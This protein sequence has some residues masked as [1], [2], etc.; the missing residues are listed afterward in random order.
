MLSGI[1]LMPLGKTFRMGLFFLV[2]GSLAAGYI[3]HDALFYPGGVFG[4]ELSNYLNG[5]VGAI[6]TGLLLAFSLLAFLIV[7][8]NFSFRLAP[9]PAL[10]ETETG[11]EEAE[12]EI[13]PRNVLLKTEE[14][15]EEIAEEETEEKS[16]PEE[17]VKRVMQLR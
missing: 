7:A 12:E 14:E 15:A 16:E 8:F 17:E 6:G 11:I 1:K 9:K 10:A 4:F 2:F 3:F 5:I 13:A